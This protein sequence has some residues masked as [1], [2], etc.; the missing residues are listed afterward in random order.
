[1]ETRPLPAPLKREQQQRASRELP[2]RPYQERPQSE[3]PPTVARADPVCG[4]R[5]SLEE[6]RRHLELGPVREA[7]APSTSL[8]ASVS[9]RSSLATEPSYVSD[10]DSSR[11]PRRLTAP[12]KDELLRQHPVAERERTSTLCTSMDTST[13]T[14]ISRFRLKALGQLR[15]A[16]QPPLTPRLVAVPA[17]NTGQIP[18][19][20]PAALSKAQATWKRAGNDAKRY[21]LMSVT[22]PELLLDYSAAESGR[23]G[24][25]DNASQEPACDRLP[26]KLT[27][28]QRS[29]WLGSEKSLDF[30]GSLVT[31]L[32]GNSKTWGSLRPVPSASVSAGE[33]RPRPQSSGTSRHQ[34]TEKRLPRTGSLAHSFRARTR[35]PFSPQTHF[36]SEPTKEE[37]IQSLQTGTVNLRGPY[38]CEAV[39]NTY[40]PTGAVYDRLYWDRS[41][42]ATNAY[43]LKHKRSLTSAISRLD[44]CQILEKSSRSQPLREVPLD[45]VSSSSIFRGIW[46]MAARS[47]PVSRAQSPSP[48]VACSLERPAAT[49]GRAK[50]SR[51]VFPPPTGG[52]RAQTPTS[53][54]WTEPAVS[55]LSVFERLYQLRKRSAGSSWKEPATAR[56][57]E[58]DQTPVIPAGGGRRTVSSGGSRSVRWT[59]V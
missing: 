24:R 25:D 34:G 15:Q 21:R 19:S 52:H 29:D 18:L 14:D 33:S 49:V 2:G 47:M 23:R 59:Y 38:R 31:R 45:F 54:R 20:K 50:L 51:A 4:Y 57:T 32:E 43:I 8:D 17:G 1:M 6:G 27:A 16:V 37:V 28:L 41:R 48:D 5:N 22:K 46:D 53:K 12:S 3:P 7:D 39:P 10:G 56:D 13:Q 58:L 11:W 26:R 9:E 55:R 30:G 42:R 40:I 36:L 35:R 44:L